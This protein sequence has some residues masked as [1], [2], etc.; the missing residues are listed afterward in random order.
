MVDSGF[1]GA[2]TR[3][4]AY[5]VTV[6]GTFVREANSVR[7]CVVRLCEKQTMFVTTCGTF[8]REA[9]YVNDGVGVE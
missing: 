6:C 2:G 9:S 4:S 7:Y 1:T 8:V 5:I 3:S